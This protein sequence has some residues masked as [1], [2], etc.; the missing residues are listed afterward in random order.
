[1]TAGSGRRALPSSFFEDE[2]ARLIET[3]RGGLILDL[4][5]GRG[6]HALAAAERGLRVV[7][8]DHNRDHLAEL[9][10]ALVE[11]PGSVEI[12]CTDLETGASPCFAESSFA[13]ILVFRYL[14]RPLLPWLERALRPGG[15]LVYETFTIAQ[16]ALGWGPRSDAFLLR[17][18]ELL[19]RLPNLECLFYEE[20][21]SADDPAAE[22]VRLVARRPVQPLSARRSARGPSGRVLAAAHP[23]PRR[24]D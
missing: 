3:A 9:S 19:D 22:T 13:G 8:V 4:A 17:P 2:L 14:H 12:V 16:R 6:R 5:C 10:T 20:G 21:R 23:P 24:I 1:M 18:G 11:G 7:A 15:L